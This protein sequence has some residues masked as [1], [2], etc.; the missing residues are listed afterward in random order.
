MP[1][2]S[3]GYI[4]GRFMRERCLDLHSDA[5][6]ESRQR[7]VCEI[8]MAMGKVA[9]VQHCFAAPLSAHLFICPKVNGRNDGRTILLAPN[10]D[11]VSHKAYQAEEITLDLYDSDKAAVGMVETT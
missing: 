9:G 11:V 10:G 4:V 7:N 6:R 5:F 3:G 1:V 8:N 2:P